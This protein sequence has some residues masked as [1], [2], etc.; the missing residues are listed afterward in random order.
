[1]TFCNHCSGLLWG[2]GDQGYQCSSM[3]TELLFDVQTCIVGWNSYILG[4]SPAWRLVCYPEWVNGGQ[5]YHSQPGKAG[6]TVVL[7][8]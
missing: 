4:R 3:S 2:I 5:E 7:Y 8:S 6:D 1:M